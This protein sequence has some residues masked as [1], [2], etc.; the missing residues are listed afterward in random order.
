MAQRCSAH[1]ILKEEANELETDRK[2]RSE[3]PKSDSLSR[4]RTLATDSPDNERDGSVEVADDSERALWVRLKGRIIVV[5]V[6][7]KE[8][9]KRIGF[10]PE[11]PSDETHELVFSDGKEPS[12]S[13]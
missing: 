5:N 7:P 10:D 11:A 1:N 4:F 13:T 12:A 3:C 8:G 6:A 9:L 2:D